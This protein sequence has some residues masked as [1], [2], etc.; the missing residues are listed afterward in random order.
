MCI[1]DRCEPRAIQSSATRAAVFQ[2]AAIPV[3]LHAEA[4]A[5]GDGCSKLITNI[6]V[7]IDC[8]SNCIIE[9]KEAC[10]AFYF[11][12]NRKECRLV[13]YTDATI[14]MGSGQG[15][16]KFVKNQ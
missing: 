5:K 12:K 10:V 6:E 14:D 16:Q 8:F 3:G 11:N 4:F 15:W 13:L 2:P 7:I 1:R 9:P